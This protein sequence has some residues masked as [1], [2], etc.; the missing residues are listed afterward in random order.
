MAALLDKIGPS[1]L[2]TWSSSG[3]GYLTAIERP[4][5]VKGIRRWKLR[6]M[7]RIVIRRW[8]LRHNAHIPILKSSR[9]GDASFFRWMKAIGGDVTI[10]VL[11]EAGI[12]GNGHTMMLERNNKQI[13]FRMIAWIEGHVS[14]QK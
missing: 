13:M 9:P 12:K 7:P 6:W 5:L 3:L 11:P 2:Q 10:D 4:Q 1:I 8:K 14:G